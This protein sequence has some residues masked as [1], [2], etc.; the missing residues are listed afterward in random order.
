M[1]NQPTDTTEAVSTRRGRRRAIL[2]GA[3]VLGV[4]AAITLAAWT[5]EVH[6]SGLFDTGDHLAQFQ[7]NTTGDLATAGNWKDYHGTAAGGE[8]G[9]LQFTLDGALTP[10]EVLYA[11]ISLRTV[12]N[13][14]PFDVT[15]KGEEPTGDGWTPG[16]TQLY[17]TLRYRVVEVASPA[18][19][20]AGAFTSGADYLV[21][22]NTLLQPVAFGSAPD[23]IE[24]GM[25]LDPEQPGPASTYCFA[26]E[27]NPELTSNIPAMTAIQGAEMTV[28]WTFEGTATEQV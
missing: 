19:C 4:G 1:Q 25:S 27:L 18:A 26:V 16:Q 5:D 7:A 23:A 6:V 24:L 17:N 11:P 22:G 21:G 12:A 3:A 2:A 8:T 9:D 13:S 28:N 15:L 10:G 14:V 20:G